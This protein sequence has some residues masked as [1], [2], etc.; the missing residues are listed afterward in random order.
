M[1]WV[2]PIFFKGVVDSPNPSI[3]CAGILADITVTSNPSF[4]SKCYASKIVRT[5]I[6][7]QVS[8][9]RVGN[10]ELRMGAVVARCEKLR[11]VVLC[12]FATCE[13]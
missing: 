4:K 13:I 12:V 11:D 5:D 9:T 2:G 6:L 3:V 10:T 1:L 8:D 7:R